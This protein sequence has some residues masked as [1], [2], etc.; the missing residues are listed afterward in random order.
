V[1]GEH[2]DA[3]ELVV[4]EQVGLV[5][6]TDRRSSDTGSEL[7]LCIDYMSATTAR[8]CLPS[9]VWVVRVRY[10]FLLVE[11]AWGGAAM[12]TLVR[13][14]LDAWDAW[15]LRVMADRLAGLELPWCVAA[16][17]A[18]DLFRGVQ[19]RP[20]A[21]VEIAVPAAGFE[22]VAAC[23]DD[24]DFYVAHD[25]AVVPVTVDAMRVSHQT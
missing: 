19:T 18:L 6:F 9:L 22:R 13:P 20:H 12:V 23:F 2:P 8:C 17:W 24:C 16:G 7:R 10:G 14:D 3:F 11:A 1:V 4:A 21:D 15:G 25:G 5:D